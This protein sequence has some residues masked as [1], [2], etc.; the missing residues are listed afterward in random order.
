VYA[1]NPDEPR[2]MAFF[3]AEKKLGGTATVR[4][5][6]K[7]PVV[8]KLAPLGQVFGRVFDAD[9]NPLTGVEV[10]IGA[11]TEIG[12]ELYHVA[13]PPS[14]KPVR[15]D[16]EG[17]FRIEGVVPGLKFTLFLHAQGPI[18]GGV[19]SLAVRQVQVKAGE[20]LNVGDMRNLKPAQ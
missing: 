12:S 20:K 6:E 13:V 19:A 9:G 1:L 14:G 2:E 11:E 7:G 16:K 4:G 10:S 3:H 17:R 8:V 5:D 18:F 15:T